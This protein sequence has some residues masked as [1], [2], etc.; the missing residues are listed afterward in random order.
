VA[1]DDTSHSDIDI[2]ATE[3]DIDE[4]H[5]LHDYDAGDAVLV[6]NVISFPA[7]II[8]EHV[9]F[10]AVVIQYQGE[11]NHSRDIRQ[12]RLILSETAARQAFSHLFS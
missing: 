5:V 2:I 10:A 3:E 9:K 12:E 4:V 6:T 11:T 1:S 8:E 7:V